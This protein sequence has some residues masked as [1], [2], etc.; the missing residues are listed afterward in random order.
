VTVGELTLD[1][2]ALDEPVIVAPGETTVSA[3][4]PDGKEVKKTVSVAQ[5]A[6]VDVS[7]TFSEDKP[8]APPPPQPVAVST[9]DT[10]SNEGIPMRTLAYVAGGIGVA[11]FAGFAVFGAMS[12]S[13]FNELRDACPGD[14]CPPERSGEISDGKRYQTFANVGLA[15]GILGLGAGV[16]LFVLDNSSAPSAGASTASGAPRLVV[17]PAS[18]AVEGRF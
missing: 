1:D 11:G 6:L 9:T 5:G 7:L 4:S 8:A 15:V 12:R 2:N 14:V 3:T 17:R 18:V 13:K 10:A 16:T